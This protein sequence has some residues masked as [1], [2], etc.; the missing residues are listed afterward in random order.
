MARKSKV[1]ANTKNDAF[2]GFKRDKKKLKSPFTAV[3]DAS[4]IPLEK[5]NWHDIQMP[6]FL[7][8]ALIVHAFDEKEAIRRL[9]SIAEQ[10]PDVSQ[11]NNQAV[12]QVPYRQLRDLITRSA[13]AC[14]P[15][16]SGK[17][18]RKPY[19]LRLPP[20]RACRLVMIGYPCLVKKRR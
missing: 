7:W 13:D 11:L 2:S 19:L 15:R 5:S 6:E 17:S 12:R 16:F 10:W 3:F 18:G 9:R 14:W 20:R 4:S 8:L 1:V